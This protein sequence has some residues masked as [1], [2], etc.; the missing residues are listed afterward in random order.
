MRSSFLLLIFLILFLVPISAVSDEVTSPFL[1]GDVLKI[2]SQCYKVMSDLSVSYSD[3]SYRFSDALIGVLNTKLSCGCPDPFG[4]Y[5]CLTCQPYSGTFF[6]R[7]TVSFDNGAGEVTYYV[8]VLHADKIDTHWGFRIFFH[9]LE[10]TPCDGSEV[11]V[12]DTTPLEATP[13]PTSEEEPESFV[14]PFQEGDIV[15][16]NGKCYQL[17]PYQEAYTDIQT[18]FSDALVGIMDTKVGYC[19]AIGDLDYPCLPETFYEGRFFGNFSG[20]G[21]EIRHV[22]VLQL[23]R[24][25]DHWGYLARFHYAYDTDCSEDPRLIV[26]AFPGEE[27]AFT[28]A[29][30]SLTFTQPDSVQRI[31]I[32]QTVAAEV[33]AES[34]NP[35]VF[36]IERNTCTGES[37]NCY[38]ELSFRP[39]S[40][41]D[42]NG[43][44][45]LRYGEETKT[46]PISAPLRTQASSPVICSDRSSEESTRPVGKVFISVMKSGSCS[47]AR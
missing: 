28:P 29:V 10:L 14:S 5:Y 11:E 7:Y 38:I 13:P 4:Q 23:E 12:V 21:D 3:T 2:G 46:I 42:Y 16:I 19:G 30:T 22:L 31:D 15:R 43:T 6:G 41:D 35:S 27:P 17:G 45:L 34:S 40:L 44:I 20:P 8:L 26:D 36:R 24:P 32:S 33:L 1:V 47:K 39:S 37:S 18:M 9:N 25:S